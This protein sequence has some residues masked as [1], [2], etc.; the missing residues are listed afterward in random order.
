MI[1]PSGLS[2]RERAVILARA[3]ERFQYRQELKRAPLDI[4][5]QAM[6]LLQSYPWPGNV[7]ELQNT[8]ERAVVFAAGPHLTPA[9][10]PARIPPLMAAVDKFKRALIPESAAGRPG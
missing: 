2:R 9:D 4:D 1:S 8:I 5:E 3:A 7:R 10:L 6:A